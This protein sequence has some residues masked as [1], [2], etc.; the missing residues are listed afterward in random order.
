MIHYYEVMGK[1][2][3]DTFLMKVYS[4]FKKDLLFKRR[5]KSTMEAY[6]I[7]CKL[8]GELTFREKSPRINFSSWSEWENE[9][10]LPPCYH[11]YS[12][13]EYLNKLDLLSFKN[14]EEK[15]STQEWVL[16]SKKFSTI[17]KIIFIKNKIHLTLFDEDTCGDETIKSLTEKTKK[18]G[19]LYDYLECE[20][21][22][23]KVVEEILNQ[24]IALNS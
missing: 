4:D 24:A 5:F 3:K 8:H 19:N 10:P 14:K 9:S 13:K 7:I 17:A 12:W 2:S 11:G 23:L 18:K 1:L 21:T 20:T 22:E 15:E 6:K 16:L